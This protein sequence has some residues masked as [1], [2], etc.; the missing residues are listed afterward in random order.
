MGDP[1]GANLRRAVSRSVGHSYLGAM[2]SP[3]TQISG[4]LESERWG[5]VG[6][7]VADPE[8]AAECRAATRWML[9]VRLQLGWVP[10]LV[11][12]AQLIVSELVTNVQRY[13]GEAFPAGSVTIWHPNR[14]L[15]I[16]V[17]DKNPYRP[18]RELGRQVGWD[19]EGGRGLAMVRDLAAEH[20]G[21]LDFAGD[22]D[23]AM[24]GKVTRVRLLMPDVVWSHRHRDP[25]S[26]REL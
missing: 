20:C 2:T 12:N 1:I 6:F 25:H 21:E 23:P 7:Y 5:S 26:G 4:P 15:V 11:D 18:W 3:T 8:A 22:G 17:H 19:S 24:P 16:S 13:A 10:N 9:R 14:F